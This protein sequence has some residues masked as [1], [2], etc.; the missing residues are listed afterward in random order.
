MSN[1]YER[2]STNIRAAEALEEMAKQMKFNN[3]LLY[4]MHADN[5]DGRTPNSFLKKGYEA[6]ML[7]KTS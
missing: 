1:N 6:F 7:E 5:L 3:W 4:Q 2:K